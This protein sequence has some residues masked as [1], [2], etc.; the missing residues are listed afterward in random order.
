MNSRD[1][2]Q[3]QFAYRAAVSDSVS[4]IGKELGQTVGK[5]V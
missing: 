3:R 5:S 1:D 4:K 2:K